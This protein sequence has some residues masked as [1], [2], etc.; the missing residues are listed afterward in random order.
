MGNRA[1]E[2]KEMAHKAVKDGGSSASNC[3]LFIQEIVGIHLS[4]AW[5]MHGACT[6]CVVCIETGMPKVVNLASVTI[7]KS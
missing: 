3:K 7:Y 4:N 2:I 6:W 5:F 1:R